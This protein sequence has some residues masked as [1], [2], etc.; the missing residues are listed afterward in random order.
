MQTNPVKNLRMSSHL[1]MRSHSSVQSSIDIEDPRHASDSGQNTVLFR[2]N[3]SGGPLVRLNTGIAGCIA[4]GAIFQQ[5][6]LDHG[7]KP[8]AIPVHYFLCGAA[9]FSRPSTIRV[10]TAALG[11]SV[12]SRNTGFN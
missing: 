5:R 12:R 11:C 3:S 9:T 1:V 7:S 4:G 8:S 2:N 10:G 6:I